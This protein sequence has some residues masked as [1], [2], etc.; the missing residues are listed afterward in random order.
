MVGGDGMWL[1]LAWLV[2]AHGPFHRVR[3]LGDAA[4]DRFESLEVPRWLQR[5]T[6]SYIRPTMHDFA[7]LMRLCDESTSNAAHT[8]THPTSPRASRPSMRCRASSVVHSPPSQ[9]HSTVT[10]IRPMKGLSQGLG[11]TDHWGRV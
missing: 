3:T 7:L 8:R 2:G 1:S 6:A 10:R 11:S 5:S 9:G 4:G